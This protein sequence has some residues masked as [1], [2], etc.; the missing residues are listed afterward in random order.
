[1]VHLVGFYYKSAEKYCVIL[2]I[3]SSCVYSGCFYE[4]IYVKIR[5]DVLASDTTSNLNPFSRFGNQ[6]TQ[7]GRLLMQI[8]SYYLN[9]IMHTNSIPSRPTKFGIRVLRGSA[10]F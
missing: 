7:T 1:M 5:F 8:T 6:N 4:P 10:V 3:N 9:K 2:S